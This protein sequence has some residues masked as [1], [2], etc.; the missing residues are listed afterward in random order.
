MNAGNELFY[1]GR[2]L[3]E[4]LVVTATW[5]NAYAK[6]REKSGREI[7]KVLYFAKY[8]SHCISAQLGCSMDSWNGAYAWV[9]S[10]S[11][12]LWGDLLGAYRITWRR[13]VTGYSQLGVGF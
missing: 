8:F 11:A 6:F 7:R 2:V 1:V 13:R 12:N 5:V 3:L 10:D 4:M 9:E